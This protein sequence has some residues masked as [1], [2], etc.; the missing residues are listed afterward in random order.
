MASRGIFP[1]TVIDSNF[2]TK[3]INVIGEKTISTLLFYFTQC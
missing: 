2:A 1:R 3:L